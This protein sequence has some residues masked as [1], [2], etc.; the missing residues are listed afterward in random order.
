[1]VRPSQTTAKIYPLH[2]YLESRE[3]IDIYKRTPDR[4]RGHYQ[5]KVF[6]Y[7]D[8]QFDLETD[9]FHNF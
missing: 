9:R 3:D 6:L 8:A 5:W 7:T 1:M 4:D 2:S